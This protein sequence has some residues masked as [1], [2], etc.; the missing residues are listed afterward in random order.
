MKKI[1]LFGC[2]LTMLT[3]SLLAQA[4]S[5]KMAAT[6]IETARERDSLNTD[7]AKN[8]KWSYDLG[9]VLKGIEGLW[10]KTGDVK[11]FNFMQKSMDFFVNDNGEI[12]TYKQEDHNIDNILCGRILLILYNVTAKE[13]YR[14]A[15][16]TL[17]EQLRTQPRTNEGGFWHKKIYPNQMWL[18]GLYMGEPFYT[19]YAVSFNDTAAFND[20]A[21]QFI[22]M[23]KHRAIFIVEYSQDN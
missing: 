21:H 8:A 23:E 6:V 1:V 4:W 12:K 17:R 22:W 19:E 2:L 14:K 9:V 16:E 20:I 7:A 3:T 5:E 10:Y 13:K 18:D 15:V 11:Y